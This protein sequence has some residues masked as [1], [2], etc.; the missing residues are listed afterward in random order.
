M[1]A[2]GDEQF[3]KRKKSMEDDEYRRKP[4]TKRPYPPA[5]DLRVPPI[6]GTPEVFV[7][8]S[9]QTEAKGK[10]VLILLENLPTTGILYY[11]RFVGNGCRLKGLLHQKTP[12]VFKGLRF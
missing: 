1:D 2:K 7:P 8:T 4:W 6:H 11:G 9:L 10:D 5:S 3:R 12:S